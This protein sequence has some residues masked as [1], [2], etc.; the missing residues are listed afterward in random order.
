MRNMWGLKLKNLKLSWFRGA[1]LK[2]KAIPFG[3][4]YSVYSAYS[5]IL[6]M[7]FN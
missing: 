4:L 2:N 1:A 3:S 5:V 7:Y 6:Y